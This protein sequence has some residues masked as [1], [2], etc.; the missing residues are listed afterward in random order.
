MDQIGED[1]NSQEKVLVEVEGKFELVSTSEVQ[2]DEEILKSE[3]SPKK[4]LLP[5]EENARQKTSTNRDGG[6]LHFHS[7]AALKKPISSLP[8]TASA[9]AGKYIT[10]PRK[11]HFDEE[12]ETLNEK[13]FRAWLNKKVHDEIAERRRKLEEDVSSRKTRED[14]KVLN[15]KAFQ[16]WVAKKQCLSI[17]RSEQKDIPQQTEDKHSTRNN[18]KAYEMWFKRKREEKYSIKKTE[19]HNKQEEKE[20]AQRTDPQLAQQAYKKWLIQKTRQAREEA[21]TKNN[22]RKL[23]FKESHQLNRRFTN[24]FHGF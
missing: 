11:G 20:I 9:P 23:F 15:E 7:I 17:A 2:A 8:R 16:S 3:E 18:E 6:V 14:K 21:V 13:A 19:R 4:P 24:R 10:L 12:R 22:C 5:N 1:I